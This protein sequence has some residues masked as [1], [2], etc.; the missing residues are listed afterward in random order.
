MLENKDEMK[1]SAFTSACMCVL[2]GNGIQNS[3]KFHLAQCL[4]E[5]MLRVTDTCSRPIWREG[6][7]SS[8][9]PTSPILSYNLPHLSFHSQNEII[10]QMG[11]NNIFE[12]K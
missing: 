12:T 8:I 11:M 7:N 10:G 2:R 1:T 6:C 3:L 4:L 9:S 5:R